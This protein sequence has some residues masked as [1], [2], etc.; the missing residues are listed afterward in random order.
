[1]QLRVGTL[2]RLP[3]LIVRASALSALAALFFHASPA[4]AGELRKASDNALSP[5]PSSPRGRED[6]DD[7][8]R[9]ARG[10]SSD[11]HE[12]P[13]AA[14][15]FEAVFLS[16]FWVPNVVVESGPG[17]TEG[18]SFA[19]SPYA[20]GAAGYLRP[21]GPAEDGTPYGIDPSK[22]RP[23]S[24]QLAVDGL[25]SIDGSFGRA[26]AAARLLTYFRL[27]LDAAY[28][29]YVERGAAG[30]ASSAWLGHG[31]LTYRFAQNDHVQF[32]AGA[33]VRHWVDARGWAVGP[34]AI[35]ALDIAWGRPITTAL[36][37]S[38]GYLG[39][40]AWAGELRATVGW[41]VGF[42]EVFAG[43]DGVWIGGPGPTAY[44]GGPV[45]GLRAYL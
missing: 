19:S 34:D 13:L 11:G 26:Q 41:V 14:A 31:H 22:R 21:V 23:V 6:S 20:D 33:G 9:D 2:Q 17:P 35:Y 7:R 37:A 40:G 1:L 4:L 25:S 42:G 43:Y 45:V 24:L 16:P 44:L 36:E 10:S 12:N 5:A 8:R 27:E 15:I 32:R 39:Q 18:W 30:G 3:W 38:G 28:G 29:L